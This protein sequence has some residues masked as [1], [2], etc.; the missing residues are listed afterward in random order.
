MMFQYTTG[1]RPAIRAQVLMQKASSLSELESQSQLV[2]EALKIKNDDGIS[3][4][5]TTMNTLA[6][7]MQQQAS[8]T[9]AAIA[10]LNNL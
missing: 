7:Q 1:L 2:E 8:I 6:E 5:H 9:N 10:A 4:L 3:A